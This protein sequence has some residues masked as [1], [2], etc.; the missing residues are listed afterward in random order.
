[1]STY[2]DY[3]KVRTLVA[4]LERMLDLDTPLNEPLE[5]R[6]TF[7]MSRICEAKS[8]IKQAFNVLGK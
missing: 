2:D 7:C 6:L 3:E 4:R 1:M 5:V 8:L